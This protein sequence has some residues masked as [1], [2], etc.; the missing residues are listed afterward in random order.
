MKKSAILAAA[1]V[2]ATSSAYAYENLHAGYSVKEKDPFYIME[3]ARF[4]AYSSITSKD[5]ANFEKEDFGSANIVAF[6]TA[7]EVE[8]ITGEKF[9][10]AY[11][12]KEYEKLALLNRSKLSLKTVPSPLLNFGAYNKVEQNGE[13]LLKSPW[14]KDQIEKLEPVVTIGKQ[15]KFKTMTTSYMY[16][17]SDNLVRTDITLLSANDRLYALTTVNL[18]EN[19]F[20]DKDE[21]PEENIKDENTVAVS[22]EAAADDVPI[23]VEDTPGNESMTVGEFRK[24]MAEAVK[25]NNVT[26]ADVMAK[27]KNILKKIAKDHKKLL[28]GFKAFA[29]TSAEPAI[30]YKDTVTGNKVELPQQW[31]YAQMHFT[32][33][34]LNGNM[35]V[36]GSVP[37]VQLMSN[38]LYTFGMNNLEIAPEVS[39]DTLLMDAIDNKGI[40]AKG[41]ASVRKALD[42]FD[43]LLIS[44]SIKF[45]GDDEFSYLLE[46][47][48][49]SKLETEI[50][51]GSNLERLKKYKSDYF[52]LNTYAYS[53]DTAIGR[54]AVD[55]FTNFTLF[56][57]F[58]MNSKLRAVADGRT[59]SGAVYLEKQG[60]KESRLLTE[61]VEK[62]NI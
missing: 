28:K 53:V 18:V 6:Y 57:D 16:S 23:G 15:G 60:I 56:K 55:I 34:D 30:A 50:F 20:A 59:F 1:L 24:V 19:F 8:K 49:S 38:E 26:E 58:Y 52:K 21:K 9:D 7:D 5:I 17:Q 10:T 42:Y 4:F 43:A 47:P 12:D 35:T 37:S 2:L 31:F 54:G 46:E 14:M 61:A 40:T 32:D 62:W 22:K 39:N 41:E 45:T 33:K 13:L 27:D 51:L 44:G 36:A 3:S 11:F 48:V 29:P 25:M